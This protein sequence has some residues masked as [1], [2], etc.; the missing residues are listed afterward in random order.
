MQKR[1]ELSDQAR[2]ELTETM[3]TAEEARLRQRCQAVLMVSRG[4]R[5][6]EIATDLGVGDRTVRDWL[7]LYRERGL[8]GLHIQWAPG[9]KP[10]I[11]ERYA[12]HVTEWVKHGPVY[13][14]VD[15]ANWT[16]EELAHH[17]ERVVGRRVSETTMRD[18]CHRHDIRPYRP[19]YRFLR[20]DPEKQAS[21]KE[22]LATQKTL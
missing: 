16:Y 2:A 18:F 12:L 9:R 11:E 4:I 20:G 5:A 3:R 17:F 8:Q 21:A 6:T 7:Q 13:C 19:T 22:H 10:L 15:R 1:I 14:G